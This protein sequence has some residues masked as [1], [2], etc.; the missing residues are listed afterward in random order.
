MVDPRKKI[1]NLRK[2]KGWSL[3]QLARRIGVSD[4]A[5]YNWF[6]E[7]DSMPTVHILYAVCDVLGTTMQELFTD[8]ETDNFSPEQM[9][10][11]EL[12][13]GMTDARRKFALDFLRGLADL[14]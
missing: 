1:D 9:A 10:A 2:E 13:A 14:D 5:V 7:H 3:S 6:N 12:L 11:V 4:T 8:A